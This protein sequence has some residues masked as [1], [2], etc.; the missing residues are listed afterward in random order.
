MTALSIG[1]CTS[2]ITRRLLPPPHR[3]PLQA[4]ASALAVFLSPRFSIPGYGLGFT[5]RR[6]CI[7]PILAV[8]VR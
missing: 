2:P 8:V 5:A 4:R 3:H 7:A 6:Y 1:I